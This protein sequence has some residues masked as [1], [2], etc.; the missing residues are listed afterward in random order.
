MMML[1]P[2]IMDMARLQNKTEENPTSSESN[3][4]L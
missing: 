2:K 4:D 3:I 1:F